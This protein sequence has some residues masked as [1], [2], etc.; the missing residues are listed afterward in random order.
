MAV[1]QGLNG[2]TYNTG[3]KLGEGGEGTVYEISGEPDKVIKLY[4]PEKLK[5]GAERA[6]KER[7]LKTM[8]GMKIQARVDGVLRLA[9]PLDILYE[10]GKM[11]GFVMYKMSNMLKIYDIQRCWRGTPNAPGTK[12]VLA[13]YPKFTWKY[14][15][16]FAYN[17]AW[18]V[19]YVHSHGIVI[20]DLNQ[21]NIYADTSTGAVVLIDCDSFDI[22]DTKSGERFPCEVGLQEI[23]A[24]ELQTAG[25]LKGK[26]TEETDNFSLAVHIF[27]LL[28]RNANPF[29]GVASAGASSSAVTTANVHIVNGDCPYIK[30]CTLTIPGWA[31]DFSIL[32]PSLQNLFRKTLD[33]TAITATSKINKRATAAE[34]RTAL[35]EFAAVG[36]NP[37]LTTCTR[38][39]YHVY[40][41]HNTI[42]PWC[43]CEGYVPSKIQPVHTAGTTFGSAYGRSSSSGAAAGRSNPSPGAGKR[44]FIPPWNPAS[45]STAFSSVVSAA[46][47]RSL[48]AKTKQFAGGLA[49]HLGIGKGAG[50]TA[51]TKIRRKPYLFYVL[52]AAFG[53]VSGFVFG[54]LT[55]GA[56]NAAFGTAVGEAG[57]STVLS[58][59]GVIGGLV[60]AYL[61][62]DRYTRAMNAFPWLLMAVAA[63]LIPPLLALA[64][65]V[66]VFVVLLIVGIILSILAAI[67]LIICLCSCILG[68]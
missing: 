6:T 9:W 48:G 47:P 32:P 58:I 43:K 44:S 13:V 39:P 55:A 5:D 68:S 27:R 36:T 16:Q 59:A 56:V 33:Y 67:F 25:E 64:V 54:G 20:G 60:L 37:K 41:S 2:K 14:S 18:V 29:G 28:M 30:K 1:Y 38:N 8:L 42:C 23:L 7:K 19:D 10:Q 12:E 66:V 22:R 51:S 45:V 17:L 65:G 34:W 53:L 3:A 11:V 52:L 15:V 40:A 62:E 61:F 49:S 24:P 31:P 50:N 57:M 4:K 21:N 63:F 35:A 46:Q 26:F